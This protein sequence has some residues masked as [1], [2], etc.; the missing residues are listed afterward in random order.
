MKPE[1]PEVLRERAHGAQYHGPRR[2]RS[3][4]SPMLQRRKSVLMKRAR[5]MRMD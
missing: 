3:R 4:R 2:Y 1:G 5:R